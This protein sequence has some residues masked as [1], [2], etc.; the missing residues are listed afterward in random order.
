MRSTWALMSDDTTALRTPP[1]LRFLHQ[2]SVS[3]WRNVGPWPVLTRRSTPMLMR[4]AA[5]L[6]LLLLGV[7]AGLA[8]AATAQ[9]ETVSFDCES[10]GHNYHLRRG[11]SRTAC[12]RH[13]LRSPPAYV[14]TSS[15][16]LPAASGA[17]GWR[18]HLGPVGSSP[19]APGP[20]PP[21]PPPHGAC[22][23]EKLKAMFPVNV[24]VQLKVRDT[25]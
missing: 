13:F 16:D 1:I 3:T 20:P 24:T 21:A 23:A 11:P 25:L 14:R 4:A 17:D 7:S 9:H 2:T 12:T 8:A 5:Q 10:R 22:S 18:F 15:G 19:P 6:S